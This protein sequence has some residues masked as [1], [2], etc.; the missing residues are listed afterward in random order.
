MQTLFR[1]GVWCWRPP[2]G[3]LRP[4][5]SREERKGK[6]PIIDERFAKMLLLLF[7][8]SAK[9]VYT[10]RYLADYLNSLGFKQSYGK[11]ADGK[12]IT[13][14]LKNT[15][16]Y[17]EMYSPKWKERVLGKHKPI[18]DQRTWELA[19]MNTFK[20]K[21]KYN[22]Q[23]SAIFP[24]K[25][26]LKCSSCGDSQTSSNPTGRSRNYLYYECHENNCSLKERIGVEK[27][28]KQF[29]RLLA[30]LKPSRR[31][32]KLFSTMVFSEWDTAIEESKN[33]AKL[34][35]EK[36]EKYGERLTSIAES[37]SKGILKDDEA[38][39]QAEKARGEI[40]ILNIER[41]DHKIEEYDTK[42]VKNFTKSF[43]L[44]LDNLWLSLA[45]P[46]KQALQELIFP[47]GLVCENKKIRT[48]TLSRCFEL[49]E[50][51]DTPDFDLVTPRGFEPRFQA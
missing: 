30:S 7:K 15:F 4:K 48:I 27:A 9:M 29:L 50:A 40:A 6:P 17:G 44:N 38:K 2:L 1:N 11:E 13:H 21:R 14:I 36:V 19:N 20:S 33:K 47:K 24:L 18:I 3:Y 32:L 42:V 8:K 26:L 10:K 5:G 23:D 35:E 31:V 16:Y 28:H 45:L 39:S 46:E 37:N 43:L 22:I 41:S 34:I 12:L 51:L 25:G 49:I